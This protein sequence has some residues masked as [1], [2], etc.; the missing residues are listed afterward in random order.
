MGLATGI[1]LAQFELPSEFAGKFHTRPLEGAEG[2]AVRLAN[3]EQF[4][5]SDEPR[6]A[7]AAQ[8]GAFLKTYSEVDAIYLSPARIPGKQFA[9]PRNQV[10]PA[11]ALAWL[12]S[13]PELY[14]LK[15]AKRYERF[16]FGV[17]PDVDERLQPFLSHLTG[18]VIRLGSTVHDVSVNGDEI[19]RE[20]ESRRNTMLLPL[21]GDRPH[22]L[23][24]ACLDQ[25]HSI[26][27]RLRTG[28]W[29]GGACECD[30]PGDLDPYVFYLSRA[31][32]DDKLTPDAACQ[33]LVAPM[34]GPATSE[35]LLLGLRAAERASSL[36]DEH[37]PE[38]STPRPDVVMRHYKSGTKAASWWK[39]AKEGYLACLNESLRAKD[40]SL[41]P[42]RPWLRYVG[43]RMEFAYEYM[44]SIEHVQLAGAA[45]DA[46][47][48]EE[49]LTHLE[50]AVEAMYNALHALGE[51][52][53]D[54]SDRGVIAVLAEYGYRPL[55]A[56]FEKVQD[57]AE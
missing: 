14:S 3:D 15:G 43:K 35:R 7:I 48:A 26:L 47:D 45:R 38:F 32:F 29:A 20:P 9:T 54:Q 21:I 31:A 12:V 18:R 34:C 56:E 16:L 19:S 1:A 30:M 2:L 37:D 8:I 25:L 36:A 53:A 4:A 6:N 5:G 42:G 33:E 24:Q 40:R 17:S 22:M 57:A 28:E 51:V 41:L 49:Q 10:V 55:V 46:G 44:N 13:M 50:A 39:E 27:K 23:P 52:A 11:A